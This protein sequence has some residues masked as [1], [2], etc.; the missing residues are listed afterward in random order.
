MRAHRQMSPVSIHAPA[1]RATRRSQARVIARRFRS[2]PPHGG[3]LVSGTPPASIGV[4]RSTP[5][6]GGRRLTAVRRDR[7]RV[8]I[9]AP[10]WRATCN[11]PSDAGSLFRSTPPHGGRHRVPDTGGTVMVSIHAPAWGRP[12]A[13][14]GPS[15]HARFDPRPRMEGDDGRRAGRRHAG[16]RSTPP[17]GGRQRTPEGGPDRE[18]FRSTPPHGGRRCAWP[19]FDDV[20]QVSIHAPAM[21]GDAL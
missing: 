19:A 7:A 3:R 5:P 11:W 13:P 6:H 20:Q 10:A 18:M 17:H 21:E 2:T 12:P 15:R 16:F 9:H 8:S 14:S 1:W 4:F